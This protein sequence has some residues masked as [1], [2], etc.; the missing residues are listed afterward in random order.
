MNK[1]RSTCV[2]W[3]AAVLAV[4]AAL[5]IASRGTAVAAAGA[6]Q[7]VT[8]STNAG[9]TPAN[10]GSTPAADPFAAVL[11]Y[12]FEQPRTVVMAIEAKIRQARPQE[13]PEIEERLVGILR[14]PEATSDAKAWACRQLRQVGS[15]R[16]A[17][18]LA[19]LLADPKLATY[20]RLAL[21]SIPGSKVDEVLRNAAGRLEGDLKVG[22]IL[23]LGARADQKAAGL[24]GPLASDP[25]P[26]IAEAAIF[27][28]GQIATPE[29]LSALEA[30]RPPQSLRRAQALAILR[31]AERSAAE[32]NT[33]QA[34]AIYRRLAAPNQDPVVRSAALRGLFAGDKAQALPAI[35]AALRDANGRMRSAAAQLLAERGDA[36]CWQAVLQQFDSLPLPSQ[37]AL[38]R[39]VREPSAR[40]LALRF[41]R[42][43][44]DDLRLAA[45]EALGRIGNEATAGLLLQIATAEKDPFQSQARQALRDLPGAKAD[46]VLLQTARQGTVPLRREA[47]R[48]LASRGCVAAAAGLL[49]LA[50]DPD[51]TVRREALAALGALA[52]ADHLAALVGLLTQAAPPDRPAAEQAVLAVLRRSDP[53]QAA[54]CLV[55]ALAGQKPEI[56][57]VLLRLLPRAPSNTALEALRKARHPG[58]PAVV[59]AAIRA[60]AEWPEPAAAPDLLDIARNTADRTHRILA[61]RGVIRL[62]SAKALAPAEAVRLLA[63]AMALSERPDERKLVLAALGTLADPAG[64]DLAQ[65]YLPDK[66]VELEAATAVVQIAKALRR[67]NPEKAAAAIRKVLEVCQNPSARQLA[68]GA[69]IVLDQMV[70]IA[71]QG[72]A[73]S[74]DGLE[75]DGAAG[76]DQAAIDGDLNTYWDEQDGQKLYRL[77]VTFPQ[78]QTIAAISL[79]GYQHHQYAP[80]D[81]EVLADGRSIKRVENAQYDENFLVVRLEPTTCRTVELRITGYYGNSPAIREL[82]IYKPNR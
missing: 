15:V 54:A 50:R 75:K 20:A 32:G 30:A 26:A 43:G 9:S 14:S 63:Q 35:T 73:T 70:N 59:D 67:T 21:Q 60:L 18:A 2:T 41:A 24:V 48:A 23:T 40:D 37:V 49:E 7:P 80:K 10:A 66:E 34:A 55:S 81:F 82:G 53:H 25:N 74:P 71:S 42:A 19:G 29:A 17:E 62:A 1:T 36:A 27:A 68:E 51:P 13:L 22:V 69:S 76:G 39:L 16:S 5:A 31:C 3:A 64:L 61:L 44:A 33:S 47:I 11:K 58:E 57:A 79:V 56:Q 8:S 52:A 46:A 78:A 65:K 72:T 4:A 6:P 45:L 28:L 38:L 12:T 77:V